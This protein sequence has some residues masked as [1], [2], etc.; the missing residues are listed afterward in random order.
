MDEVVT[1][2]KSARPAALSFARE[3]RDGLEKIEQHSRKRKLEQLSQEENSDQRRKTR[4]QSRR[5]TSTQDSSQV[6]EVDDDVQEGECCLLLL[7][8]Y[9]PSDR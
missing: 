9:G 8:I 4:S 6:T 5:E 3:A 1:A 7:C 2:F